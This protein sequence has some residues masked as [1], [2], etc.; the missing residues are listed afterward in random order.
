MR[1]LDTGERRLVPE[2]GQPLAHPGQRINHAGQAGKP[3]EEYQAA[4]GVI[5]YLL[6]FNQRAALLHH[7]PQHR[8]V[9][10][11]TLDHMSKEDVRVQRLEPLRRY[12]LHAEHQRASRQVLA[13]VG[14]NLSVLLVVERTNR[15]RLHS[16]LESMLTDELAD[17]LRDQRRTPLPDVLIFST[18]TNHGDFPLL[19]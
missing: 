5:G 13:D 19:T 4:A 3:S 10:W 17:L 9:V 15:R 7:P 14:T 6:V 1:Q 12:F 2:R 11:L 16:K 18:N 8:H